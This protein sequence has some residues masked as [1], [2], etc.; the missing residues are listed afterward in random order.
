MQGATGADAE[1]ALCQAAPVLAALVASVAHD[2]G[3]PA[4]RGL[5]G[6]SRAVHD[7][8]L[9]ELDATCHWTTECAFRADEVVRYTLRRVPPAARPAPQPGVPPRLPYEWH[10]S[11]RLPAVTVAPLAG[12][13][14]PCAA[15][16]RDTV[17]TRGREAALAAFARECADVFW[18]A[19]AD[20]PTVGGLRDWLDAH[21]SLATPWGF[22]RAQ[23]DGLRHVLLFFRRAQAS[24]EWWSRARAA[25]RLLGGRRVRD[26]LKD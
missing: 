17:A 13:P 11:L 8:L 9:L 5:V 4:L 24:Y 15:L 22:Y 3:T 14:V 25:R 19:H 12:P 7:A 26:G 18:Y 20:A 2:D 21:D 23:M 1:H 10:V 6:V 16:W